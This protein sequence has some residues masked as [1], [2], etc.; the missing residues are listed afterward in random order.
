[1]PAKNTAKAADPFTG[2]NAGAAGITESKS[3]K[4]RRIAKKRVSRV[5]KE[6]ELLGNLSSPSYSYTEEE[7]DK[8]FDA[9]RDA[10]GRSEA[11]F[12]RVLNRGQGVAGFDF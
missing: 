7:I 8:V 4:F 10:F 1:M 2:G 11:S 3:D 5:L 6:A 12:R 9:L